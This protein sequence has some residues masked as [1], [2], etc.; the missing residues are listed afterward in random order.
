MGTRPGTGLGRPRFADPAR[1]GLH[2]HRHLLGDHYRRAFLGS[3][4]ARRHAQRA[5][6]QQPVR[7]LDAPA[8]GLVREASCGRRGVALRFHPDHSA[9]ADHAVHRLAAGRADVAGHPGGDGVLQ[10]VA[11]CAGGGAVPRL[12]PDPLG[13]LQPA[14][15]SERGADRLWRPPA[16]R[17]AGIHSRRD[18]DQTGQQA[19]RA[20]VALRQRH[21]VHRQSRVRHSSVWVSHS[22]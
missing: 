15:P 2:R 12:R 22:P 11:H 16:E 1:S 20:V 17:A 7:S 3:H 19:G 13:L 6:G 18:A 4:L 10:P 21:G 14:A 5:M 8:A 9:H